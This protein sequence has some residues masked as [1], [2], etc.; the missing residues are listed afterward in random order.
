[1]YSI[2]QVNSATGLSQQNIAPVGISTGLRPGTSGEVLKWKVAAFKSENLQESD[3]MPFTMI[4]PQN[5]SA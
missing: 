3:R 4:A 2:M 1:M 5:P